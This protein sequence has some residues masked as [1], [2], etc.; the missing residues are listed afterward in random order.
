[1]SE[2][3]LG[4]GSNVGDKRANIARAL[5]LLAGPCRVS[6]VSSLYKTE[7]VGF[8]D[9]DWFLNCAA[10]ADTG[11][12]PLALLG[13]LRSIEDKMGRKKRIKNG[14]RVI[15]LDILLYD[16][17]TLDKDGLVIPH[18]RM[19]ERLFVL[20]PLSEIAPSVVHPVSGKTIGELARSLRNPEQ[21]EIYEKALP[22]REHEQ[23]ANTDQ[24][25]G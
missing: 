17:R 15:D 14:P 10:K 12:D 2:I 19:H 21:V 11:L 6:R 1:M 9:Q 24:A 16:D 5:D 23:K 18:P 3:W 25:P 13:A 7:P 4:L 20:A 8:K 22:G